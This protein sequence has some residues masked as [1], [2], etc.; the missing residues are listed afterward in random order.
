MEIKLKKVHIKNSK[1]LLE[2]YNN[3]FYKNA[4]FDRIHT[5]E[6]YEDKYECQNKKYYRLYISA[7]GS[8]T[9]TSRLYHYFR[10]LFDAPLANIE[11]DSTVSVYSLLLY[12]IDI[13]DFL[14]VLT[15]LKMTGLDLNINTTK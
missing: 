8:F 7:G 2:Y 10:K 14:Q 13:E 9:Q 6:V 3:H 1:L 5:F 4:K 11:V 15:Y 12:P